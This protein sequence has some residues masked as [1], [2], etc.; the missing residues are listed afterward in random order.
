MRGEV[1]IRTGMNW[2]NSDDDGYRPAHAAAATSTRR[3]NLL[4]DELT[5]LADWLSLKDHLEV[6]VRDSP[7]SG[8]RPALI[9]VDVDSFSDF[10]ERYG[11]REGDRLLRT[12]ATR[13]RTLVDGRGRAYRAGPDK[14]AIILDQVQLA[15]ALETAESAAAL[16]SR[17][18][19][20]EGQSIPASACAAVVMLGERRR[21]DGVIRDCEL[22]MFRAK[23]QGPST[24]AVYDEALDSWAVA[25]RG[26]VRRLNAEVERLRCEVERLRELPGSDPAGVPAT[27][28]TFKTDHARF[29]KRHR[30]AG[31]IY[32]LLLI[33]VDRQD[34]DARGA[35]V[36]PPAGAP[37]E[38]GE[39]GPPD[40]TSLFATVRQALR[41]GDQVYDLGADGLAV[42]LPGAQGH[43]AVLA[44][45]R[46][47]S[48]VERAG[49]PMAQGDRCQG[50]GTS[51]SVEQSQMGEPVPA[52]LTVTVAVVEAGFRHEASRELFDEA[53]SLLALSAEAGP[54]RVVWPRG[55]R[56]EAEPDRPS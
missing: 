56:Q 19:S 34:W 21:A 9:V 33:G 7:R 54:N 30:R 26:E 28:E 2:V 1:P 31:D 53:L 48:A 43:S 25:E 32:S 10:N 13:V 29:F 38:D 16:A 12:L 22:T 11:K 44:A 46:V 20:G 40:L 4:V 49:I 27:A 18:L 45:E 37:C 24:V 15:G 50:G 3:R 17:P 39:E 47:R 23:S 6:A 51:R 14:I 42:L 55:V 36:G 35:I 5:G 52:S 8:P 41:Q